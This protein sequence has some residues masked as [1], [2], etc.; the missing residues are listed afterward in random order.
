MNIEGKLNSENSKAC[1]KKGPE[2]SDNG[3]YVQACKIY[4]SIIDDYGFEKVFSIQNK[5]AK[6]YINPKKKQ[7]RRLYPNLQQQM[8]KRPRPANNILQ[9]V[10]KITMK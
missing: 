3:E 9:H 4:D 8:L 10:S 1:L 2:T 5:G 6:D 7:Q